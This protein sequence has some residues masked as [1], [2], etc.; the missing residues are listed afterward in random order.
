[1]VACD[2]MG[3]GTVKLG[4]RFI[5]CEPFAISWLLGA[6]LT[7]ELRVTSVHT[8]RAETKLPTPLRT[9]GQVY[10][11]QNVS[12]GERKNLEK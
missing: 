8:L 12:V 6:K 5:D 7:A 4:W 3:T 1:M 9:A 11:C 2:K 10:E